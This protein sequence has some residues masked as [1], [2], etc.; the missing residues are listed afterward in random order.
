MSTKPVSGRTLS[1][2][3]TTTTTTTAQ[4]PK[5]DNETSTTTTTTRTTTPW[6]WLSLPDW[7][8]HHASQ[9]LLDNNNGNH[10]FPPT[11]TTTPKNNT[12]STS[13]TTTTPSTTTSVLHLLDI[14]SPAD[15][16]ARHLDC[17]STRI[18]HKQP[19]NQDHSSSQITTTTTTTTLTINVVAIPWSE[20]P[21]R[22]FE[23][24]PRQRSFAI[25][26][27]PS[28][29]HC[30]ST[31]QQ[32]LLP[33]WELPNPTIP[34]SQPS[35]SQQHSKRTKI[36][37]LNHH[38]HKKKQKQ[39]SVPQQKPWKIVGLLNGD[40][41]QFWRDAQSMGLSV[42]LHNT[43]NTTTNASSSSSV[44]CRP[45]WWR[46]RLWE[47]DS[48][49]QHVLWP[50]IVQKLQQRQQR[51]HNTT[52][53]QLNGTVVVWDLGA[54]AGRDICYLAEQ[55]LQVVRQQHDDDDE[56]LLDTPPD[57][58]Q[59]FHLYALDQ[60][61]RSV[62]DRNH[63]NHNKNHNNHT[64]PSNN[65]HNNHINNTTCDCARLCQLRGVG[66]YVSC[67]CLDVTDP[68][69][70]RT[71][72]QDTLIL[73]TTTQ[74]R[75]LDSVVV[76]AVRFWNAQLV[77]DFVVSELPQLVLQQAATQTAGSTTLGSSCSLPPTIVFAMSQ[78][79]K[80]SPTADWNFAHP[81][82]RDPMGIVVRLPVC[83]MY[84]SL[85]EMSGTATPSVPGS[86]TLVLFFS[87][88]FSLM[89]FVYTVSAFWCFV[90]GFLCVF[91]EKHVLERTQLADM[92]LPSSS[93]STK[94]LPGQWTIHCDQ[95]VPDGDHGRTLIQFLAEFTYHNSTTT[96]TTMAIPLG[97]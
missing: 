84:I 10:Q 81:K 80:A 77:Q 3:G 85:I 39:Q 51:H 15:Y 56:P 93:T 31:L 38:N 64:P 44:S 22:R 65:N 35:Q 62:L 6:P 7:I 2:A 36:D 67:H 33:S 5:E 27:S 89:P 26:V 83:D 87:R 86:N 49:V 52:N 63:Q 96:T 1:A 32:T 48:M 73:N 78:F 45:P 91:Q 34:Q 11:T 59:G 8:H 9:S 75:S 54:G 82:V 47:P 17:S 21:K 23:L 18:P 24:P 95:V 16:H 74:Q 19:Q 70:L 50:H 68:A 42:V 71:L 94:P 55:F 43:T 13:T 92:F 28:C 29:S 14:R 12:T 46:P 25:V 41:P 4:D 88:T 30:V 40:D 72:V 60:R 37:N 79:G 61:Y 97:A 69:A 57:D 20:L 53:H 76:Y 90:G 66:P 58:S